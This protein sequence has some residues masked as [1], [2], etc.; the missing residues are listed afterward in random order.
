MTDNART[1][2]GSTAWT[3]QVWFATCV[4]RRS[5]H[6][7]ASA[8][9]SAFVTESSAVIQVVIA[10]SASPIATLRSALNPNVTCPAGVVAWMD[11]SGRS[12]AMPTLASV[13]IGHSIAVPPASPSPCAAC[14]SPRYSSALGTLTGRYSTEPATRS[15]QSM[16][17]PLP[18]RGGM[19]ECSPGAAGAVPMTPRNGASRRVNRLFAVPLPASASSSHSSQARDL[20]ASPSRCATG[21]SW[22]PGATVQ[23]QPPGRSDVRRSASMSPGS[24]PRTATG[25]VRQCPRCAANIVGVSSPGY[26]CGRRHPCASSDD[27]TIVSPGST[28]S[29]GS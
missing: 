6:V 7:L 18:A 1:P 25:P 8:S 28:V 14:P 26:A 3:P 4:T 20:P 21:E 29:A 27:T 24:A 5:A 22:R 10:S 15:L 11:D 9:A 19:V 23:P 12:R 16:L 13:V 2:A 17:P